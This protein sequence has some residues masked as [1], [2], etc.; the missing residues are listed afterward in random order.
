MLHIP[1]FYIVIFSHEL[2]VLSNPITL[3]FTTSHLKFLSGDSVM[4]ILS[5]SF[6]S[7]LSGI[8]VT[9]EV[10]NP[11]HIRP[12]SKLTIKSLPI[13]R[14]QR[15]LRRLHELLCIC[16]ELMQFV[17]GFL[18]FL[19]DFLEWLSSIP[20]ILSIV[21]TDSQIVEVSICTLTPNSPSFVSTILQ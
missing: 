18:N 17:C 19:R 15:V 8:K 20:T 5:Q 14:H 2:L 16:I 7:F 12:T 13:I 9:Y 11:L 4:E 6:P 10:L 21:P 3:Y 1:F